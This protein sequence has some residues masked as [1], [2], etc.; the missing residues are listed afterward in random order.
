MST[1]SRALVLAVFVVL[2][3]GGSVFGVAKR[4]VNR[5]FDIAPPPIARAAAPDEIARGGRL[6]RTLCL[7]CHAGPGGSH[8]QGVRVASALEFIGQV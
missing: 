6:F 1:L 3:L 2:I 5:V 4:R 8:A 7:D